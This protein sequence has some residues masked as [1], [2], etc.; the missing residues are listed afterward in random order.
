[1]AADKPAAVVYNV[2]PGSDL[3]LQ[4]N[5]PGCTQMPAGTVA[6]GMMLTG[7]V[8]TPATEPGDFCSALAFLLQ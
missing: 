4:I 3:S 7:K 2:T 6:D 1:V 8:P 5:V